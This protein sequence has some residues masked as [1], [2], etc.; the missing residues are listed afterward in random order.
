MSR[1]DD[2]KMFINFM[3][4][5]LKENEIE[6]IDLEPTTDEPMSLSETIDVS[7]AKIL[8]DKMVNNDTEHEKINEIL[9]AKSAGLTKQFNEIKETY[10][11]EIIDEFKLETGKNSDKSLNQ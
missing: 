10:K 5:L 6:E 4:E 3:I 1:Q 8:M 11:Q 9:K 7:K 2:I